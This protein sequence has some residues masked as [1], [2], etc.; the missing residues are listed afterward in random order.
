MSQTVHSQG[1]RYRY[2]TA[3]EITFPDLNV[4]PGSHGLILGPSGSGKTTLLH[5]IAGLTA[6]SA[7]ELVVMGQPF[8]AVTAAT[9]DAFRRR[10]IALVPQRLHLI[11]AI[12]VM[13]N[14]QLA[15]QLAR[16]AVTRD[17]CLTA[18]HRLGLS[19]A[20]AQRSPSDLSAGEAQRVAIA[21]AAITRPKLL[22]ADEPTSALDDSNT[23]LTANW[24]TQAALAIEAD[25]LIVTHD[26]RLAT[27]LPVL[28]NLNAPVRRAA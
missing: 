24:L 11:S 16:V 10:H 2:S 13:A 1:L 27:R 22:L 3:T 15:A 17:D 4:A 5:L 7:G 6:P 14:L 28:V 26:R 21:R 18:L 8:H 20:L 12:S 23:E 25:L 9:R 19:D